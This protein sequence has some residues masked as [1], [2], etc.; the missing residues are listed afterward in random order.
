[1]LFAEC[2]CSV[3]LIC[4]SGGLAA[5]LV[6]AETYRFRHCLAERMSRCIRI[7][8]GVRAKSQCLIRKAQE[9]K[10]PSRYIILHELADL[11]RKGL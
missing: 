7:T 11:A 6:Y 10:A 9:N 5:Q 8:A 2:N 1:M 3:G 4:N